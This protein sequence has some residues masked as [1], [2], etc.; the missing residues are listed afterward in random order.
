MLTPSCPVASI[1]AFPDHGQL[2]ISRGSCDLICAWKVPFCCW[3]HWF[4]NVGLCASGLRSLVR[5]KLLDSTMGFSKS[6]VEPR[7][8]HLKRA[9]Q[10]MLTQVTSGCLEPGGLDPGLCGIWNF[11]CFLS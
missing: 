11:F 8:L 9:P 7:S 5:C 6:T 2:N 3:Y 1:G 4:L 10:V